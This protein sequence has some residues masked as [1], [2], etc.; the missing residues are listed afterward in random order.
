MIEKLFT[1]WNGATLGTLF[2]I[3]RRSSFVGEDTYGNKYYE[4]RKPSMGA[5]NYRRRYVVYS[6][7]AEPSKVP[8][9]WHGWLHHTFDAPPTEAPLP[10]KAFEL[11]HK[12]NMTGTVF[13]TK[14]KG[15]LSEKGKRQE[16][17][18]DY[19]AWTPDA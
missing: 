15:S 11:D 6:G 5:K 16:T 3:N 7:L 14:P 8:A 10:R 17:Y 9:D 1:W 19:E 13:A 12:P 18:A 4:D 2:D